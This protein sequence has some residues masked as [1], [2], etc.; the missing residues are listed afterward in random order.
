LALVLLNVRQ[1]SVLKV[2]IKPHVLPNF[3]DF[4]VVVAQKHPGWVSVAAGAALQLS[5]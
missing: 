2:K 4:G 3:R 1:Q 5:T